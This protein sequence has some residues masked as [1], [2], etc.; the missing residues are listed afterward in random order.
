MVVSP[1]RGASTAPSDDSA[2]RY[3][4]E[5]S[6]TPHPASNAAS[7]T[8]RAAPASP[9]N[10]FHVPSPTTGPSRRSS[11]SQAAGALRAPPRTRRQRTA[12]RLLPLA[13]CAKAA[14]RRTPAPTLLHRL[15]PAAAT[16]P[17]RP[18]RSAR[19]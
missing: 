4:G 19:A 3:I 12:G 5:E 15:A 9:P 16:T 13:P 1:R 14:G 2:P 10:V 11:I 18:I 8:V 7:T 17:A 6:N